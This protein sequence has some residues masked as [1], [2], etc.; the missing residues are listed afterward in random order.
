MFD[1]QHHVSIQDREVE[2]E[3]QW[4]TIGVVNGIQILLVAFSL[5]VLIANHRLQQYTWRVAVSSRGEGLYLERQV[6]H[7]LE[8]VIP[9]WLTARSV[10][11]CFIARKRIESRK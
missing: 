10:T 11:G 8:G 1:D 6:A 4:Q 9:E 7:H 5:A 2:G 3:L